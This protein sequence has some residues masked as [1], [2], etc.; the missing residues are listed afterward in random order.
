[1]SAN[2]LIMFIRNSVPGKVQERLAHVIGEDK[3]LDVYIRMLE[4]LRRVTSDLT[5]DKAVYYSD[6]IETNDVFEAE[7]YDKFLQSGSDR[8]ER[9]H[10]AFSHSFSRGYKKV[11]IV[12]SDCFEITRSHIVDAFESL[13]DSDTVLGPS[14]DGG[15]YLLGMRKFLPLLF[16]NKG[17]NGENV[18][19]DTMLDLRKNQIS[20]RLLET[21]SDVKTYE[22]LKS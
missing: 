10:N 14:T 5:C 19:L 7:Y 1:M 12:C 13:Q 11:V 22:D 4:H 20:F 2:L 8:G 18:F 6:F 21:L 3:A 16:I 9:L 17:W 15:Y